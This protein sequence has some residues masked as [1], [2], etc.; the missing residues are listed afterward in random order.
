MLARL[1]CNKTGINIIPSLIDKNGSGHFKLAD[2]NE[3][4][5][6]FYKDLYSSECAFSDEDRKDFLDKIKL[7]FLSD[8][9]KPILCR[10][11][12]KDE[13]S[14][15]IQALKGGKPKAS[16][17][18]FSPKPYRPEFYKRFSKILAGPLADMYSDSFS[19]AEAMSAI[20]LA[21]N[22]P[23]KWTISGFM[24]LGIKVSPDLRD[25]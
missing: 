15:A 23:L 6:L 5:R 2:I 21:D 4:M 7:P 24:Y 25:L 13:V 20:D 17:E 12:S 8:E 16:L 14:E 3:V 9:Q 19:R 11:I 22:F 1:A 18:S 10:Q